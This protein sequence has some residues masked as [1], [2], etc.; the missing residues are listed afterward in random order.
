[1]REVLKSNNPVELNFAEAV[2]KDAGIPSIEL[3]THMSIRD[4]SMVIIPRRLMVED[5]DEPRARAILKEALA[6]RAEWA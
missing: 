6:S 1:M 5:E 4:G 2:L 3:D